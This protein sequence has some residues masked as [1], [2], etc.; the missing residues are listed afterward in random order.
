VRFFAGRPCQALRRAVAGLSVLALLTS[1]AAQTSSPPGTSAVPDAKAAQRG[2]NDWL[3]RMQEA[4]GRRAYAGTFVVSAGA[5]LSSSRIWHVCDGEQQVERVESLTGAPRSTFRHNDQVVT[6]LSDTKTVLTE[7]RE[8]LAHFSNFLQSNESSIARFY[9]LKLIGSGRV[10]GLDADVLQL[11]PKDDL[12]YGYRVWAEKNSG[13]VVKLQTLDQAGQVL[14]QAAYSE[15][16]LDAPVSMENLTRL[17]GKTEGYR[18]VDADPA[19]T[20]AA[21]EGWVLKTDVPGFK[22]LRCYR[23]LL[24]SGAA[25]RQEPTL[26]WIFSD[27]LASV[28]LF[29]EAFDP[30]RHGQAGSYAVGATHTLARR[31]GDWW[32]TVVGEVPPQALLAFAQGLERNR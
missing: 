20:S 5:S 12:R 8:S 9:L 26:Q 7:R 24:G 11:Q 17:M 21:M 22:P 3:A 29:I 30:R 13:L 25:S 10:A 27:G 4:S 19:Q 32:L 28:S 16:Q 2:I 1:V 15:L 18:R 23:R 14:E 6:F 31:I